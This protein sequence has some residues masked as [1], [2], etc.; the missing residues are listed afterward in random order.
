MATPLQFN[1][2]SC[3]VGQHATL[4]N[5]QNKKVLKHISDQ[6]QALNFVAL[7]KNANKIC[8]LFHFPPNNF[9]FLW[10]FAVLLILASSS[11]LLTPSYGATLQHKEYRSAGLFALNNFTDLF[12]ASSG[13]LPSSPSSTSSI[14]AMDLTSVE[15]GSSLDASDSASS[16]LQLGTKENTGKWEQNYIK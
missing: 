13:S 15:Q 14:K 3:T 9:G 5:S 10:K 7:Q 12:D 4:F 1:T 2:Y 6:N 16:N 11:L 8:H